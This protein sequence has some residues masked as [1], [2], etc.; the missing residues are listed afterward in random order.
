MGRVHFQRPEVH[1]IHMNTKSTLITMEI[2]FDWTYCL[3]H[4]KTQN[5]LT[6]PVVLIP[7]KSLN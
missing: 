4:T 2:L 5:S 6:A 7:K 3:T 1:H